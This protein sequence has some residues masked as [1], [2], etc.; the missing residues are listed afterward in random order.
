ME[1]VVEAVELAQLFL[2][3]GLQAHWP[4]HRSIGSLNKPPKG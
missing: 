4:D 2:Y 1:V 3:L